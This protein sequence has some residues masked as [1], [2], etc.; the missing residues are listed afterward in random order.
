M[1]VLI[2]GATGMVGGEALRVCLESPEVG[3]VITL[4]RRATGIDHPKLKEVVHENFLE[5]CDVEDAFEGVDLAIYC[6][7]VY[8]GSVS[9][10][11]FQEI[12]VDYCL[13]FAEALHR[14]SPK[15]AVSFLSGGGADPT[16]KSRFIFARSLGMA[17]AALVG[18]GFPRVFIFR[19]GYIYPVVPRK[20]P[21][22]MYRVFRPLYPLIRRVYPNMGIESDRLARAMVQAG[23][24]EI[25]DG[26]RQVYENRDIRQFS[27]S[28]HAVQCNGR[29][30]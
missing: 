9:E 24:R 20:E 17:E 23:V 10:D 2:T 12:I 1:K 8:T 25:G 3:E 7:G 6:I 13:S 5:L 19:P 4:G 22:F 18:M 11:R 16:G 27:A 30:P 26:V 15:A 29:R 21:N 28:S 14:K